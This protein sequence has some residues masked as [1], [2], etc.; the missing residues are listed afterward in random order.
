M[1]IQSVQ[2]EIR[3]PMAKIAE[4][5]G[6]GALAALA[7]AAALAA[8]QGNLTPALMGGAAAIVGTAL[9]LGVLAISGPRTAFAWA[10]FVLATSGAR[11][12]GGL[13]VGVW[14][15]MTSHPAIVPFWGTFL[16]VSFVVLGIEVKLISP[17]LRGDGH[18][19]G[20][21]A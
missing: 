11:M 7:I 18:E 8:I 2:P 14:M 9:G 4:G 20:D 15:H 19:G 16:L 13:S 3:L 1:A 5:L 12:A 17:I 21:P 10:G 6:I